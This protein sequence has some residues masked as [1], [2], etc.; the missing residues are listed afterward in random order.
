M[1]KSLVKTLVV[2]ILATVVTTSVNA[3]AILVTTPLSIAFDSPD[4]TTLIWNID[5]SAVSDFAFT[6]TTTTFERIDFTTNTAIGGGQQIVK[7]TAAR[8]IQNIAF[9]TAVNGSGMFADTNVNPIITRTTG[10]TTSTDISSTV[11]G[12]TPDPITSPATSASGYMAFSFIGSTGLTQYGWAE[13]S[14]TNGVSG[15]FNIQQWGYSNVA[16]ESI[17]VGEGTPVPEASTYA[18]ALGALVLG[19][20]FVRRRRS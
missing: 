8:Q 10:D 2:S 16:G 18:L 4:S 11:F 5:G 14:F 1:K 15:G 7:G 6:K 3:A 13:I 17:N 19:V 20:A 9:G 12:F